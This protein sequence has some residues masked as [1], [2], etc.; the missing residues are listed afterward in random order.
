MKMSFPEFIYSQ[1]IQA[2]DYPIRV[3]HLLKMMDLPFHEHLVNHV[4]SPMYRQHR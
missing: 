3:R 4:I 2:I 1:Y